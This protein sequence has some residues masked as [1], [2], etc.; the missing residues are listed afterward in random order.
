MFKIGDKVYMYNKNNIN[1][2]GSWKEICSFITE[3]VITKVNKT[4]Y[5]VE[6]FRRNNETVK[7]IK[8]ND[9]SEDYRIHGWFIAEEE[10]LEDLKLQYSEYKVLGRLKSDEFDYDINYY[11]LLVK[12]K[13]AKIVILQE[14]MEKLKETLCRKVRLKTIS[15]ERENK[16]LEN[17]KKM[18]L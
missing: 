7:N 15:L 6:H 1:I 13:K 16:A 11:K 18:I 10:N 9:I 4:S 17:V 5:S 14:E 8:F 2:D 12:E 3:V